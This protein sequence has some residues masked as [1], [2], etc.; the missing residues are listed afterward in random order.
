MAWQWQRHYWIYVVICLLLSAGII[1]AV[2]LG[3]Q[4]TNSDSSTKEIEAKTKLDDD[5]GNEP[6]PKSTSLTQLDGA[7]AVA[8][9]H[10]GVIDG[11][12]EDIPGVEAR[13]PWKIQAEIVVPSTLSQSFGFSMS[14]TDNYL[15][16]GAPMDQSYGRVFIYQTDPA[17]GFHLLKEF[18]FSFVGSPYQKAGYAL[19]HHLAAAPDF[20]A[21]S[22]KTKSNEGALFMMSEFDTAEQ[23]SVKRLTLD[24]KDGYSMV[25]FGQVFRYQAP[26]VYV[27]KRKVGRQRVYIYELDQTEGL[28]LRQILEDNDS[29]EDLLGHGIEVSGDAQRLVLSDPFSNKILVYVRATAV[30]DYVL[31]QTLDLTH[32]YT[33][34]EDFHQQISLSDDGQTLVIS[35]ADNQKVFVY[36][37]QVSAFDRVQVLAP[38]PTLHTF[39]G[40]GLSLRQD[41][42]ALAVSESPDIKVVHAYLWSSST[43]QFE[44][45]Q[46]LNLSEFIPDTLMNP[47]VLWDSD[48]LYV[49]G[50][51]DTQHPGKVVWL[52]R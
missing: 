12:V 36:R 21:T 30:S 42:Q 37:W 9:H 4:S 11:P 43:Q 41:G 29:K 8:A 52:S 6:L 10:I 34:Q 5:T 51:A 38:E 19:N 26:W 35:S 3:V 31:T 33:D 13:V 50:Q 28:I 17:T 49:C 46:T 27:T 20:S 1:V 15:L 25:K 18:L 44:K 7:V 47:N 24:E 39:F 2:V 16:V 22:D 45:D 23:L 40:M 48:N 32:D 14:R